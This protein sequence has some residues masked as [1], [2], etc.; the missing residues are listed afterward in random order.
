M[1]LS[2]EVSWLVTLLLVSVRL[3]IVMVMTPLLSVFGLPLQVR[4]LMVLA[5]AAMLVAGLD[6]VVPQSSWSTGALLLAVVNEALLGSVLAFAVLAGFAAFQFAGRIMDIQ[7]GFGVAGLIDPATRNRAPLLGT[8]LNMTAL[9]S[10][11][12]VGGH[13]L[14]LRGL[15][16]S[17]QTIPPG[18]GL[19]ALPIHTVIG[20]FGAIFVYATLLAGPVM[21]VILLL[22]ISMALMAR[23][24]PQLNVFIIGLPL[25]I[26][27]GLVVLAISLGFITPAFDDVFEALFA[28]WQTTITH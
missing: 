23:V 2:A 18:T 15:A 1:S 10:F 24:L 14:L 5:L 19:T 20:E 6:P 25:K 12:L 7:M 28:G 21:T 26:L 17:L 9:L 11:F 27:V 13:R 3:G 4:L 22:D 8:V 16:L